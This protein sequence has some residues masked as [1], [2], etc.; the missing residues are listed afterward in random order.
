MVPEDVAEIERRKFSFHYKYESMIKRVED[1]ASELKHA[2]EDRANSNYSQS[3]DH[4][5]TILFEN[6][7]GGSIA[8]GL[9][10]DVDTPFVY[11]EGE[12]MGSQV[13]ENMTDSVQ[14]E[15]LH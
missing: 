2:Y 11:Q 15:T 14:N 4:S 12:I 5:T 7:G 13:N 10:T 3:Y 1:K 6:Q 9:N 8:D